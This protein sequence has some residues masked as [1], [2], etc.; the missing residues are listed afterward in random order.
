MRIPYRA[1]LHAQ[2]VDWHTY[3]SLNRFLNYENTVSSYTAKSLMKVGSQ[4][5]AHSFNATD[6]LYI[7]GLLATAEPA[8]E[9]NKTHE[10]APLWPLAYCV[11]NSLA[12]VHNSRVW[13]ENQLVLLGASVQ[14]IQH[15]SCTLQ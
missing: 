4:I 8:S 10:G 7:I 1:I 2:V 13:A 5:K 11:K 9:L 15:R 3:R 14:I 12:S 6:P